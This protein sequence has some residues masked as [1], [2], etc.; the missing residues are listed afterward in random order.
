MSTHE[1][2]TGGVAALPAIVDMAKRYDLDA[3]AFIYTFKAMAMPANASDAEFVSCCLVAREHGLN[4]LIKEIY[5][6]KTRGGGIQPIV[7]VDGWIKKCNEHPQFDGMELEDDRDQQ[8]NLL[9][10]WCTI[11]RKD[12]KHPTRIREDFKECAAVGG[13]VWKSNP[14]R[15]MRNRVIC[16]CARIAFGFAGIMDPDE[17]ASWHGNMKDVTPVAVQI[18]APDIPDDI[19]ETPVDQTPDQPDLPE[20]YADPETEFLAKL[21]SDYSNCDCEAD[22]TAL[23]KS[24]APILKTLSPPTRKKVN[25]ILEGDA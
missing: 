18:S 17:F 19:P 11:Y 9:G 3:A 23:K 21:Q 15:M 13:P 12:R 14:S 20:G 1:Q 16:Q 24:I 7:S 25:T 10:M 6:M 2:R 5:F 8:G 4:P 22:V